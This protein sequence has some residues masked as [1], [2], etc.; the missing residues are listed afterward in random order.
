MQRDQARKVKRWI[1]AS[2]WCLGLQGDEIE[3]SQLGAGITDRM[4]FEYL[5]S[6]PIEE[7]RKIEA[8]NCKHACGEEYQGCIKEV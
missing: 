3:D 5:E 6:L 2:R 1:K 8:Y 4:L 7:R